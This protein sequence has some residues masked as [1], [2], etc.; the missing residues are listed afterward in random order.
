MNQRADNLPGSKRTSDEVAGAELAQGGPTE[1]FS[2]SFTVPKRSYRWAILGF[3]A[4]VL[5]PTALAGWY[6]SFVA[7]E[8]YV[9]E[10]RYAVRTGIV[11]E[12]GDAAGGGLTN[13]GAL[14]GAQD[15]F[16]LE[17]YLTSFRAM[18]DIEADLPL[19][20]MLGRD[21]DDPVR[22]YRADL[23][24]EDLL[25]FWQNAVSVHF[26]LISGITTVRVSLYR[27]EDAEAVADALI[28]HLRLVVDSLSDEAQRETKA[29][30]AREVQDARS[31]LDARNKEIELFRSQNRMF[32]P[33]A[34]TSQTEAL[35]LELLQ[36]ELQ[37]NQT[38]DQ[39][40]AGSPQRPAMLERLRKVRDQIREQ[41]DRLGGGEDEDLPERLNEFDRLVSEQ[42]IAK[43]NLTS[44]EELKRESLAAMTLGQ[45]Q[46]VVFVPPA[47]PII[48]T[49]PERLLEILLVALVCFCIWLVLRILLASLRTP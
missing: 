46:L 10:F 48:P 34:N 13:P 14:L 7:A 21:G 22:R 32:S 3:I 47:L 5:L 26:D 12:E 28:L 8:R 33:E 39:L 45:M 20:E 42:E 16:I 9:A 36:Q 27:P 1:S 24:P 23:P 49:E 37:I 25:R 18:L 38:L 43:I 17:N 6:Y 4:M 30:V 40:V 15:S 41:R 19:R 35:L 11:S 31:A 44:S 29:Y 2:D